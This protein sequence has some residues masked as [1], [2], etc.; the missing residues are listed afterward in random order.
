M[1]YDVDLKPWKLIA[2]KLQV[3]YGI[4]NWLKISKKK[5]FWNWWLI[6]NKLEVSY[7]IIDSLQIN[8]TFH[9]DR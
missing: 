2:N 5:S 6:A 7:G 4:D 1:W 9:R 3:P 8:Y